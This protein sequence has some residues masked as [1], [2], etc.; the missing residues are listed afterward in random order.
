MTLD[1]LLAAIP[2]VYDDL[3]DGAL[4]VR[5]G[6]PSDR[7]PDPR[8]KPAPGRL[9]VM[10]HR[11]QLVRGLRYWSARAQAE[12]ELTTN[13][14]VGQDVTRACAWLA[15]LSPD[16]ARE[17][18]D[19]LGRNLAEW[20]G[21]AWGHLGDPDPAPSVP[22]GL[23]AGAAE[24]VVRVA[25]AAKLLGCSVRTIQRRVP[26]EQRT[27]GH[28]RLGDAMDQLGPRCERR[29]LPENTCT[30]SVRTGTQL[31]AQ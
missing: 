30:H 4:P 10:E 8:E 13:G 5:T 19:E 18:R 20:L 17:T 21:T 6:E 2:G 28:V 1:Q 7:S 16:L 11:H 3:V 22:A 23:P 27:G 12:L 25:D 24:Q 14:R 31:I 26:A 15:T 29:D 9:D